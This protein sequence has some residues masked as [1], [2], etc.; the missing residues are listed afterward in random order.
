MRTLKVAIFAPRNLWC[1]FALAPNQQGGIDH[2]VLH[3]AMMAQQAEV[4]GTHS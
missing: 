1:L 4:K 2:E 3:K